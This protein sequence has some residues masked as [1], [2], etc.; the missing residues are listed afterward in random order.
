MALHARELNRQ[1]F[2]KLFTL[3]RSGDNALA[4]VGAGTSARMGFPTWTR[5][6]D[7]L[8][9]LV[10][11]HHPQPP[12][13]RANRR[14]QTDLLWRAEE[15]RRLLSPEDYH[16][17]IEHAFD[18]DASRPLDESLRALVKLPFRHVLTTNYDAL[19]ER[20]HQ[21]VTDKPA[22][23]IE[24]SDARGLRELFSRLGDKAYTRRYVHLHGLASRPETV[25]L[26]DSDY[27]GR[28]ARSLDAHRRLFAL[29]ATQQVVFIGFSLGDPELTA[30]LRE[31]RASMGPGPV[32]HF[33]L[34]ALREDESDT[35]E[36]RRL[37]E[38]FGVEPIFY[39]HTEDH[40]HLG[41][42]LRALQE[43]REDVGDLWTEPTPEARPHEPAVH[44]GAKS[45][46]SLPPALTENP[47]DPQKGHWGGQPEHQHR[48]LS[49]RVSALDDGSFLVQLQVTSTDPERHPLTGAVRFHLH[50]TFPVPSIEQP[51]A[52]DMA[53]I[54][55]RVHGA[56][57]VGAEAD[58]GATRLELDLATLEDAPQEF[59]ER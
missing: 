52:R 51:V 53:T 29:F 34:L 47:E 3:L 13:L 28:Y 41:T 5:L 7:A 38:K 23:V 19:L 6:L 44:R 11:Q 30:L 32:R 55:M 17:F 31:V 40:S 54:E 8:D 15:Y 25:V 58:N 35:L 50:D 20:A 10:E 4:L 36:R 56:F 39:P 16:S 26:T 45:A 49:A 14:K 33:A 59:R 12:K 43:G 57:T 22:D 27:M 42:L 18:D 37:K 9:A 24:W 1:A 2:Q 46:P 48:K 21:E